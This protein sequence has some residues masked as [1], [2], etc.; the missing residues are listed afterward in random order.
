[1]KKALEKAEA[2]RIEL[3]RIKFAL[4]DKI[5]VMI[6]DSNTTRREKYLRDMIELLKEVKT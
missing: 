4:L 3:I 2:Y 6:N 1:M 5:E